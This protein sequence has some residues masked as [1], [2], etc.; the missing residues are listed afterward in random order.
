MIRLTVVF[1]PLWDDTEIASLA[2]LFLSRDDGLA[3]ALGEDEV[4]Q[5]E[6]RD[7]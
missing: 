2:D 5:S 6:I 4:L 1:S 3:C 7:Q